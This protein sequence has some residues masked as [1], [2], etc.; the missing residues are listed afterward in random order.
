[1]ANLNEK[2]IIITKIKKK[3]KQN[4]HDKFVCVNLLLRKESNKDE[5]ETPK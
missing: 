4:T 3:L 5:F 2:Q 1:M